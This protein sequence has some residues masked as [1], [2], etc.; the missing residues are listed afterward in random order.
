MSERRHY[1]SSG[2]SGSDF[3]RFLKCA[4]HLAKRHHPHYSGSTYIFQDNSKVSYEPERIVL[5]V[6]TAH[7]EFFRNACSLTGSFSCKIGTV[8][9]KK[10]AV[11]LTN[12]SIRVHDFKSCCSSE[13]CRNNRTCGNACS[14]VSL[15]HSFCPYPCSVHGYFRKSYVFTEG[16]VPIKGAACNPK[17]KFS[18]VNFCE[19]AFCHGTVNSLYGCKA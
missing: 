5:F 7:M 10:A 11:L 12:K 3:N 15:H 19:F 8:H 18:P 1:R 14:P 9:V 17:R 4:Q 6:C 13:Y 2:K 16:I